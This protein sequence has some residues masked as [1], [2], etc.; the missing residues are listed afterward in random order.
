M[1]SF[2]QVPYSVLDVEKRAACHL[3]EILAIREFP[4]AKGEFILARKTR[5]VRQRGDYECIRPFHLGYFA[6]FSPRYSSFRMFA[7][8]S[9]AIPIRL[10]VQSAASTVGAPSYID[11]RALLVISDFQSKH[12]LMTTSD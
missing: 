6:I 10:K 5:S 3:T 12:V 4:D 7:D 1:K 8:G 2:E 9:V 11:L